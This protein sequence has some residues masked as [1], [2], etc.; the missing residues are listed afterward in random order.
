MVRALMVEP[1]MKFNYDIGGKQKT[2]LDY[3][4]TQTFSF[5]GNKFGR[6]QFI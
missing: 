5:F 1:E 4:V 2:C 6:R 3:E